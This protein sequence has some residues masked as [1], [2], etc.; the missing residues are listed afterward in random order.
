MSLKIK[1]LFLAMGLLLVILP[2][3][4]QDTLNLDGV[5]IRGLHYSAEHEAWVVTT[6]GWGCDSPDHEIFIT[7]DFRTI[8][9]T[10]VGNTC[11]HYAVWSPSGTKIASTGGDGTVRL[12]DARAGEQ[13]SFDTTNMMFG[14]GSLS[15]RADESQVAGISSGDAGVALFDVATGEE[16]FLPT[17]TR[18]ISVQWHPHDADLMAVAEDDGGVRLW[19]ADGTLVDTLLP[20]GVTH[21]GLQWSPDGRFLATST[22]D[23]FVI[24]HVTSHTLAASLPFDETSRLVDFSWSADGMVFLGVLENE[25]KAWNFQTLDLLLDIPIDGYYPT[26]AL[27]KLDNDTYELVYSGIA[28]KTH[29]DGLTHVEFST[30]ITAP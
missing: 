20:L 10:F 4:A 3:M 17:T 19:T 16:T 9:Q 6:G 11:P 22:T 21:Y 7:R 13:I 1:A 28:E 29:P 26:A 27:R 15:W 12:W 5:D 30:D 18:T 8:A 24:V 25:I 2:G 14:V 23:R